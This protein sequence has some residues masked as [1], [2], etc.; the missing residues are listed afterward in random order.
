M[1]YSIVYE[2]ITDG[3]IEEGYYYAHIPVLDLTTQGCGIEG[4]KQAVEELIQVWIEEKR[5]NCETVHEY[6]IL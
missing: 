3:S 5:A 2:K 4:V 6:E 1:N